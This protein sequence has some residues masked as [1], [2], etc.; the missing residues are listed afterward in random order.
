MKLKAKEAKSGFT[1]IELI[2]YVLIFGIVGTLAS[3]VLVLAFKTKSSVGRTSEVHTV[4]QRALSQIVERVQ[5]SITV[6]DASTTLNLARGLPSE[7]PT[8]FAL[9]SGVL[10]IKEGSGAAVQI[11]PATLLIT[12]LTFTKINSKSINSM[13][14]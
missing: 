1:L 13:R 12:S 3:G 2:I 11:T 9:S 8:I 14:S 7:S 4:T 10:T 5:S 6:S